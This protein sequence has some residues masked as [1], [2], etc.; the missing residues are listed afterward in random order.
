M[1]NVHAIV[2]DI[3]Q[4]LVRGVT[5]STGVLRRSTIAVIPGCFA[6][7]VGSA[8]IV[9]TTALRRSGDGVEV[10]TTLP[11]PVQLAAGAGAEFFPASAGGEAGSFWCRF[12]FEGQPGALRGHV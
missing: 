3:S 6:L 2:S 10:P 4:N 12:T 8:P 5:L 1:D 7:N 11:S 9:L